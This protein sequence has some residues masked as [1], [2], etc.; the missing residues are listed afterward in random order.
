MLRHASIQGDWYARYF[1]LA[2][3]EQKFNPY[4]GYNARKWLGTISQ[5]MS[6]EL[7]DA[8][9]D[10]LAATWKSWKYIKQVAD[11][12]EMD[13]INWELRLVVI[14]SGVALFKQKMYQLLRRSQLRK[15]QQAAWSFLTE[16]IVECASEKRRL[17]C[18]QVPL[19][20]F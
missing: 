9:V 3:T 2:N 17:M 16:R 12:D 20:I 7:T 10:A 8:G 5:W 4:S 11:P 13:N 18:V 19:V 14:W 6:C 1:E 15:R